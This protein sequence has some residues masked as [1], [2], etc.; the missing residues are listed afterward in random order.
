MRQT[1]KLLVTEG[2]GYCCLWAFFRLFPSRRETS[3]IA[4][5]L[6]VSDRAVRYARNNAGKCEKCKNCLFSTIARRK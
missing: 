1:I 3:L 4:D 2:L 5:R 6:G